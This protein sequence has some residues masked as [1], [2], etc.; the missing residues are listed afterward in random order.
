MSVTEV[1]L[2]SPNKQI[3]MDEILVSRLIGKSGIR[4]RS[5]LGRVLRAC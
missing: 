3:S 1:T 5:F 4:R 2:A